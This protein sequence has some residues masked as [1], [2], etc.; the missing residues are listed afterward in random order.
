MG[1]LTVRLIKA[2]NLC[3]QDL[4]G[5]TDPY[6][7]IELE[8]DNVFRD[9]DYGFQNS[10]TKQGELN[11][12]WDE[13]F[14]FNIPTLDN[15]VLTLKV[16]DSDVGSRDDKVGKCK[17]KLEHEGITESPKRI[18]KCVDRNLLK[19]NGEITVDISFSE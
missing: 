9:K 2:T 19:A 18:V 7:R 15:M 10:S 14:N 3:D 12:V 5:K 6:V 4:F 1:V 11:P 13:T 8:Q 17:I 16:M